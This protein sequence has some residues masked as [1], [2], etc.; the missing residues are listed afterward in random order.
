MQDRFYTNFK[1]KNSDK[2]AQ[3]DRYGNVQGNEF[4]L[5]KDNAFIGKT[6]A[7]LHLYTGDGFDFYLP[8]GALKEKGFHIVRWQDCLPTI[9]EF[10]KVL[11]QSSQLWLIST[12]TKLLNEEY[13][14]VIKEFF[15]SGRGLFLWGDNE[16]FFQDSN[17]VS[18]ALLGTTMSGSVQGE[19]TI[20]L[21]NGNTKFGIVPNHAIT[22]GLEFLYEG[23]TIATITET[24]DLNPLIYGSAGNLVAAYY[25]KDERRAVVDGGFT[26]LYMKW[27]TAGT[28][29]FVKNAAAW[30]TNVER[31]DLSSNKP[32]ESKAVENIMSRWDKRSNSSQKE[33]NSLPN[34]DSI[35][36]KF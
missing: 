30:L 32:G 29:R 22:T 26:R 27:D 12:H 18:K 24:G 19:K 5:A 4:D 33:T 31:F 36:S 16:P 13:L 2:T 9:N 10:K 11:S 8:E 14:T 17:F 15:N 35:F 3:K 1:G 21:Q 7:V 20:S 28:A 25:E 6:I 34:I 23:H